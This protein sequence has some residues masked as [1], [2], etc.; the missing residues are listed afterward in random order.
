MPRPGFLVIDTDEPAVVVANGQEIVRTTPDMLTLSIEASP[1]PWNVSATS[2]D[3]LDRTEV[4]FEVASRTLSV[5]GLRLRAARRERLGLPA[6]CDSIRAPDFLPPSLVH[7][8]EPE[9]PQDL[10]R[11][12][13]EGTVV[14]A[15]AIDEQGAVTVTRL[16]ESAPGLD[17]SAIEAATK[18]TY[19]PARCRGA[20]VP[21]TLTVRVV[22]ASGQ[23]KDTSP[24]Q[25]R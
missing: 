9:Y 15:C 7:R 25:L 20:T 4:H 14:L 22:F 6:A 11:R 16:V 1:G 24:F 23:P 8:V 3:G 5:A 18:W 21:T 2:L 17:L 12:G 10:R 19:E 13:V